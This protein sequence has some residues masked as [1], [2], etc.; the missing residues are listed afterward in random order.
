MALMALIGFDPSVALNDILIGVIALMSDFWSSPPF[1]LC[2]L[3]ALA[4]STND[5]LI[6]TK[7]SHVSVFCF[8]FCSVDSFCRLPRDRFVCVFLFKCV[9]FRFASRPHR[10]TNETTI[11]VDICLDGTGKAEVSVKVALI[12]ASNPLYVGLHYRCEDDET[13]L[14]SRA[15]VRFLYTVGT[16]IRFK[17]APV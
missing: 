10:R 12:R 9:F 4:R 14:K 7:V 17:S 2:A 16:P 1:P 15:I 8:F 6:Y 3:P 5:V 11:T 13:L